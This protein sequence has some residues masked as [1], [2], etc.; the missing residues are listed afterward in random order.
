[1]CS[2]TWKKVN[3]IRICLRCGLMRMPDGK[4]FFDKGILNYKSKK[5]KKNENKK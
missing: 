3:D 4:L 1:M 2:H 5:V